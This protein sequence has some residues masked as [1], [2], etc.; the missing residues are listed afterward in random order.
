MRNLIILGVIVWLVAC[1][2]CAV[3]QGAIGNVQGAAKTLGDGANALNSANDLK[4]QVTAFVNPTPRVYTK[5]EVLKAIKTGYFGNL[6]QAEVSTTF[7]FGSDFTEKTDYV[8]KTVPGSG[9]WNALIGGLGNAAFGE[10]VVL[11]AT[12][13][14]S[15]GVN[16]ND[17]REQDVV[18]TGTNSFRLCLPKPQIKAVELKTKRTEWASQ[19]IFKLGDPNGI[20]DKA[21]EAAKLSLQKKAEDEGLMSKTSADAQVQ[22]DN[23]LGGKFGGAIKIAYAPKPCR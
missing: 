15:A 3:V 14:V 19:G 2:G 7:P 21:E 20:A 18:S 5:Q 8:G 10:K 22:T 1:G 6:V 11:T 9:L 12:G 13:I 16:M 23:F 17:L 4:N